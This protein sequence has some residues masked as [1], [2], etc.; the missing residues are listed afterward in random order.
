MD[1]QPFLPSGHTLQLS[2]HSTHGDVVWLMANSRVA[3]RPCPACQQLSGRIHSRYTRVLGDVSLL[4]WWVRLQLTVRKFFCEVPASPVRVFCERLSGVATAWGRTT[5]RMADQGRFAALEVGAESAARVLH[6]FKTPLTADT[7]LSY[8]R[9]R[10]SDKGEHSVRH[11]GVDDWAWHKGHRYGT[12][13]VDL[14]Q[15]Q[16]ID[17]LPDRES[18]TLATWLSGHAEIHHPRPGRRVSGGCHD[19]RTAGAAG[20][21]SLASGEESA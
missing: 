9:R 13:L 20:R 16:V 4:S 8:A 1:L 11:L 10:S 5:L 12:V 2:N 7:L 3:R 15:H 17:L 14:D 21:R 18:R 19:R 6:A